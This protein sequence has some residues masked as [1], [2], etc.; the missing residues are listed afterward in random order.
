MNKYLTIITLSASLSFNAYAED[1]MDLNQ[2]LLLYCGTS[3]GEYQKEI[4]VG[5]G[6]KVSLN[7]GGF[8]QVQQ[9][10]AVTPEASFIRSQL[11]KMNVDVS[12]SEFLLSHSSTVETNS[13]DM[14]ARVYFNFDQSA[15]TKRS[16]YVLDQ[17]FTK[18]EEENTHLKVIGHTDAKGSKAYNYDLGLKRSYT[19]LKYLVAHGANPKKLTPSSKGEKE[20]LESNTTSAGRDKNRRVEIQQL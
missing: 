8:Y 9:V 7:Q 12:C 18:I 2:S 17:V 10:D 4:Q 13:P 14:L 16:E 5:D 6:V 15:L 11:D 19:V 3:D 20:P 1:N